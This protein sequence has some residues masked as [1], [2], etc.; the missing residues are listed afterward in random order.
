MAKNK[1]SE[2]SHLDRGNINQ[3][4]IDHVIFVNVP[5]N[6]KIKIDSEV[7]IRILVARYPDFYKCYL[8]KCFKPGDQGWP[9]GGVKVWNATNE[10]MQC[11]Y[12]DSVALHPDGDRHR[13]YEN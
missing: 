6:Q 9:K 1:Q 4:G 11:F 2:K 8:S 3:S 5:E 10:Q 12:Y 7:G 13:F